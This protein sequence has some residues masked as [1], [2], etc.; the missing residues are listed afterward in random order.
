[1]Y[2]R[3]TEADKVSDYYYQERARAWVVALVS[4]SA[5]I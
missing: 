1:M 4:V 3:L 5:R 2:S